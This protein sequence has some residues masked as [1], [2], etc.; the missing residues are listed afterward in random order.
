M[1]KDASRGRV[2]VSTKD[3]ET[4][5]P[6]DGVNVNVAPVIKISARVKRAGTDEWVD[7]GE[8]GEAELKL[9]KD[10]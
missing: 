6:D 2:F 9:N 4:G 5:K 7:V 8:I 3:P 1:I 10:N